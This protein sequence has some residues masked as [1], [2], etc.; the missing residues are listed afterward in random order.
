M[1]TIV[2]IVVMLLVVMGILA[3]LTQINE[4]PELFTMVARLDKS[5]AK[6]QYQQAMHA[7]ARR[8]EKKPKLAMSRKEYDYYLTLAILTR[9]RLNQLAGRPNGPAIR[10]KY[11]RKLVAGIKEMAVQHNLE[12]A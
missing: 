10:K 8:F 6:H 12:R 9:D 7:A 5:A 4:F 3:A 11:R 2:L 1:I